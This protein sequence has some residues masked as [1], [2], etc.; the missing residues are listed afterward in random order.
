VANGPVLTRVVRIPS[1]MNIPQVLHAHSFKYHQ[2]FKI[3]VIEN[4]VKYHPKEYHLLFHQCPYS[5]ICRPGAGTMETLVT[6][7]RRDSVAISARD[8]I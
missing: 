2:S 4:V 8:R 1:V 5:F 3:S 7:V 6:A